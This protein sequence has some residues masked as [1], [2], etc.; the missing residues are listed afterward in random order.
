MTFQNVSKL[1]HW[2][3]K[4][5][6][7]FTLGNVIIKT[8]FKLFLLFELILGQNECLA[9]IYKFKLNL[10]LN[11]LIAVK[12]KKKISNSQFKIFPLN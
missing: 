6:I 1:Q 9:I 2:P 10:H 12:K 11:S 4:N 8:K 7:L 3:V 5:V